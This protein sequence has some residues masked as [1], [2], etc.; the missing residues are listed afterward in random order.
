VLRS[1]AKN[2]NGASELL[3]LKLCTKILLVSFSGSEV[4]VDDNEKWYLTKNN[5]LLTITITE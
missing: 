5:S 4:F 2:Y 3:L 1:I